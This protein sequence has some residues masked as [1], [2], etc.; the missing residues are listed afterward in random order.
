MITFGRASDENV[1]KIITHWTYR[2][3]ITGILFIV[4]TC[5]LKGAFLNMLSAKAVILCPRDVAAG[6]FRS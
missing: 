6:A 4:Q 1:C 5:V 3:C 2:K